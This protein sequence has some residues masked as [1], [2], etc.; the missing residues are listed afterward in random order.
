MS[1]GNSDESIRRLPRIDPGALPLRIVCECGRVIELWVTATASVNA[2]V[3]ASD[4]H[5]E[6]ANPRGMLTPVEGRVLALVA[7][8]YSDQEIA[9]LLSISVHTAKHAVRSSL[10]RLG[11]RNRT[12]AAVRAFADGQLP[13]A[14][15]AT[16]G[17][18]GSNER[19]D[20]LDA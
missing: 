13:A 3:K 8:G 18:D 20:A 10:V 17:T 2:R 5:V 15:I 19:S 6:R 1:R 9:H 4:A 14:T 12:E 16:S 11:A 7:Q